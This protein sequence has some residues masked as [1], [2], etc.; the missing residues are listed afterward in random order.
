MA[1]EQAP[2][3]KF[4]EGD[5][6]HLA[7]HCADVAACFEAITASPVVRCRLATTAGGTLSQTTLSRLAVVA[8]LHDCGK[9]HPGFQAKG[10]PPGK[11]SGGL[12]GH[13]AEGAAI[14]SDRALE[15]IARNLLLE[16]L[17]DW[18]VDCNLLFAALSHHGRPVEPSLRASAQ[19][20]PV[21]DWGYDP[22][23]ASAEMGGLIRAWFPDAFAA[24]G[25]SLPCAPG[26]QHL[27]NGLVS[28]ADWLGS[29]RDIFEFVSDLD[30]GYA[31]CARARAA[32]AVETI[33]LKVDH[34]RR[35]A[36]GRTDFATLTD[37]HTPRPQQR[38]IDDF[39]LADRLVILEAETGSGK[40]EAALWRF[41]RLFEAGRVDG[42]YF[43]LPT[44]SAAVQLHRRVNGAM[45]RVFQSGAPEAV[46]V[47]PGYLRAG[48]AKGHRL[49]E[50]KVKWDDDNGKD[51]RVLLSRWAA[52]STKRA[53][54]APVAV[55]TVDQA[56][57]AALKVKHAHLRAGALS[58][59][60]LVIDEVHASDHYMAEIQ[61]SL[62]GAHLDRGGHALL[63]SA[64]LG[65]LARSK[66]LQRPL[67]TFKTAIE[68]PYPSVWGRSASEPRGL[69]GVRS[70]KTVS[71]SL[72]PTMAPDHAAA[73]ALQAARAGA[74]VLVVRNTVTFA[75][76]T[77]RAVS[78]SGG[79]KLLLDVDGQPTLHHGRFA[80]EDRRRLDDAVEQALSPERPAEGGRIVIGTQTL[81]QSLDID[82]DLLLT[83][84]CPADVLLQRIGRLHRHQRRRPAGFERAEC[85]VMVPEEGLEALLEP[86]FIN[87]LGAWET[88]HGRVGVY[89]DVSGLELTRRLIAAHPVWDIPARNRFLVE[90]AT[91]PERVEALH[92]EL[93][94]DWS[95]YWNA[96]YGTGV[97]E[98][99]TAKTSALPVDMPYSELQFPNSEEGIRTRLGAEGARIEFNEPVPGP[100]GTKITRLTL[101]A[102]WSLGI[103]TAAEAVPETVQGGIRFRI[104]DREFS[105][106]HHG[107]MARRLQA[108]AAGLPQKSP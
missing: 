91:H 36:R 6:H 107:L 2:W 105:Y 80:P 63:M 35:A 72:I 66:W 55:G 8:F 12:H 76:D 88:R 53:L 86:R 99:G 87:G 65:S 4:S 16:S 73:H 40:T 75:I 46:L 70:S 18:G 58:R 104:G 19:W 15:P 51:E 50:W 30:A 24:D 49:P 47:V 74:R 78:A 54:A 11:W 64:T 37:G 29:T 89:Q 97:A 10:W 96:V 42:L 1:N 57:L 13:V 79:E 52:E 93:G 31:S 3:G 60:L 83:D 22:V 108:N 38:L 21:P 61:G 32:K 39:P 28:L 90:S 59:S 43:A 17:I 106:D 26:F 85:Q 100:F 103:E 95:N 5:S 68:T 71:V 27:F 84:L 56:M 25:E 41:I 7:H 92:R 14:F 67:P 102:H 34:W 44:R 77:F 62:L 23:A 20:R 82:A 81:E 9:L 69:A 101:P 98:R 45:K 48:D 33:G 94:A